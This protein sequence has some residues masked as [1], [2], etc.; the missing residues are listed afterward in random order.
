MRSNSLKNLSASIVGGLMLSGT[1][2]AVP[3]LLNTYIS[4]DRFGAMPI[5]AIQIVAFYDGDGTAD[6]TIE[7][8]D[9]ASTACA[10][11]T[12]SIASFTMVTQEWDLDG[13][14][15]TG[16]VTIANVVANGVIDGVAYGLQWRDQSGNRTLLRSREQPGNNAGTPD[17]VGGWPIAF[18]E[19]QYDGLFTTIISGSPYTGY[20]LFVARRQAQMIIAG[21]QLMDNGVWGTP[22]GGPFAI[23]DLNGDGCV[24]LN[25]LTIM[26]SWFGS[27]LC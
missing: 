19:A 17:F 22:S 7:F 18:S 10:Y 11:A 9:T 2:L 25:D 6:L 12:V 23:P 5:D 4:S 24:D 20:D 8:R 3:T 15:P 13:F 14:L 16:R 26:L 21:A 1:S 27:C